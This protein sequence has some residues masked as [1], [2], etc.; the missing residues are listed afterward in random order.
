MSDDM[1]VE[2]MTEVHVPIYK[3][4]AATPASIE[5]SI[6]RRLV[7][8]VVPTANE[9]GFGAPLPAL[10]AGVPEPVELPPPPVTL[11]V[12]MDLISQYASS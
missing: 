12:L 1:G 8:V 7:P 5:P 4:T 6:A 2:L 10:P 11:N 9:L 3:N